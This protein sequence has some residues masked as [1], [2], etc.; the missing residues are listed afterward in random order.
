MLLPVRI[1]F[2]DF[3]ISIG[4]CKKTDRILKTVCPVEFNDEDM[5]AADV[6]VLFFTYWPTQSPQ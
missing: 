6:A 1:V 5:P 2:P 4:V 3:R